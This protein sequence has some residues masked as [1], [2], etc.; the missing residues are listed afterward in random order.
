MEEG[1]RTITRH[2]FHYH[3]PKMGHYEEEVNPE[4]KCHTMEMYGEVE[5][6]IHS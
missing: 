6:K 2:K 1:E 4:L 3:R 5:M